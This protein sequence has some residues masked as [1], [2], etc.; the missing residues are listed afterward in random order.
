V[1]DTRYENE[2]WSPHRAALVRSRAVAKGILMLEMLF[3]AALFVI[4]MVYGFLSAAGSQGMSPL[5]A[6]WHWVYGWP[7]WVGLSVLAG[8]MS[9]LIYRQVRVV[10][11]L[12]AA[13]AQLDHDDG[14][15]AR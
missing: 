5:P 1:D 15:A 9:V 4:I 6:S 10:E 14:H 3:G 11:S 2:T 8:L 13:I 7:G 12:N